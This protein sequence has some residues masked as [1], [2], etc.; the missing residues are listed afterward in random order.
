MKR[1]RNAYRYLGSSKD[2]LCCAASVFYPLREDDAFRKFLRVLLQHRDK[3]RET[4]S[5][6]AQ[7]KRI[8]R[9]CT[10]TQPDLQF[11]VRCTLYTK[12][13]NAVLGQREVLE[14]VA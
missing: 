1:C 11:P 4:R 14:A 6:L 10:W 13:L 8:T 5:T 7:H 9:A 2:I 3:C 12:V